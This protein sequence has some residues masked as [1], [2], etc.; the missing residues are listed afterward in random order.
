MKF[1]KTIICIIKDHRFDGWSKQPGY[2]PGE[3]LPFAYCGR[4]GRE[5]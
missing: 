1:L 4:C 5:F 2:V 3:P